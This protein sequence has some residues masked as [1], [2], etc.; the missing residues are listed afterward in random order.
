MLDYLK[1]KW[2]HIRKNNHQYIKLHE[3]TSQKENLLKPHGDEAIKKK[4][5]KYDTKQRFPLYST[6]R[7]S[8]RILSFRTTMLISMSR[9][10]PNSVRTIVISLAEDLR[11]RTLKSRPIKTERPF[12]LNLL[13]FIIAILAGCI[14]GDDRIR[15]NVNRASIHA[16]TLRRAHAFR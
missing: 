14:V 4:K 15:R 2:F 1:T 8:A 16:H 10:M 3:I 11:E 13:S 12:E 6:G 9:L 5:K 7:E